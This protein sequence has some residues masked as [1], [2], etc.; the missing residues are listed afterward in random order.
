MGTRKVVCFSGRGKTVGK[1][2]ARR[3]ENTETRCE[4]QV[5]RPADK[6]TES[7]AP[8]A[9][10]FSDTQFRPSSSSPGE[11][12]KLNPDARESHAALRQLPARAL[13]EPRRSLRCTWRRSR[14]SRRSV[15]PGPRS[16]RG[17]APRQARAPAAPTA[18]GGRGRSGGGSPRM[19]SE[20]SS[21]RRRKRGATR[22]RRLR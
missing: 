14:R 15:E 17:P 4:W 10:N 2:L 1:A 19:C 7:L 8:R 11:K 18:A 6:G 22:R 9:H 20:S 12:S 16:P 13:P 21:E 3:P 5:D